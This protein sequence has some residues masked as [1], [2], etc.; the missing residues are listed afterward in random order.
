[1]D[2]IIRFVP[3]FSPPSIFFFILTTWSEH[4]FSDITAS[5]VGLYGTNREQVNWPPVT[6]DPL[7]ITASLIALLNMATSIAKTGY[8]IGKALAGAEE[9]VLGLTAEVTGLVGVL[10]SLHFMTS[11]FEGQ[12]LQGWSS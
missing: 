6:M 10:H 9:E 8:R 12:D 7:S 3:F 5:N 2:L 1:V 11:Q 4:S